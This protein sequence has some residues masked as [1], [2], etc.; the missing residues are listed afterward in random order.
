MSSEPYD[1]NW[2]RLLGLAVHEIR[3]PLSVG[4]G[5]L[6]FLTRFGPTLTPQQAQ[7]VAES[8]KAWDRIRTLAD[9]M[10]EL[11]Q[12]EEGK[13]M[14]ARERLDLHRVLADAVNTLPQ[15]DG[16][17]VELELVTAAGP[18]MIVG[19]RGRLLK[20]FMSI[21]FALRREVVSSPKLFVSEARRAYEGQPASWI[22]ITT[23]PD[24]PLATATPD[25]LTTFDEWRGGSG[26]KLALAR[27]VIRLH[28]GAVWAPGDGSR[29]G[30]VVVLPHQSPIPNP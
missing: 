26:L 20:A 25:V 1:P 29:A 19:D 5:Y 4:L 22:T 30:A 24:D 11:S 27:R 21:L 6:G 3:T 15:G 23:D 14:I 9:E 2:P 28:G 12:L 8:Q 17:A 13:L 7:Y 10:S 18:A 16:S